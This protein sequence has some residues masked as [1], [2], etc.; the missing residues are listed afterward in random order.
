[1]DEQKSLK[2][3]SQLEGHKDKVWK[4]SWSHSGNMLASCSG[5]RSVRIWKQVQGQWVCD[6]T[7]EGCHT[8]TIRSLS[9]SPQ[10]TCLATCSFD[11]TTA[12]WQRRTQQLDSDTWEQV[13][14]LEGHENEVKDVSWSTN[15]QFLATCGRDK[16]VWIWECLEFDEFE[17]IDVKHGHTQD[18]K[19]VAWMEL[20]GGVQTLFTGSYDNTIKVWQE[21]VNGEDWE[22]KQT[23]DSLSG[24]HSS[25]VWDLAFQSNPLR[26]V[27]CSDDQTI[28]IWKW[29]QAGQ[30][31]SQQQLC[32]QTSLSGYTDRP[33][34]S[35]DW[36]TNGVICMAGG[37]NHI[38]LFQESNESSGFKQVLKY[39]DAH[40]QDIN[41]VAWGTNENISLLATASDDGLVIIWKI[42]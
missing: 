16:T 4:V 32:L 12:I 13:A 37:D 42:T 20:E 38:Y 41:C 33:I 24:G 6:A 5:D 36:S 14:V 19:C 22:C 26:M 2:L 11:G 35:V 21:D 9:W 17:C 25:T 1:M 29:K 27:S 30:H 7:L 10:D 28:K 40:S 34:Y 31:N 18:V 39:E 15:G 23:L 3:V 8:R